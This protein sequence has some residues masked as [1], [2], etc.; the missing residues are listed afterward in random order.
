VAPLLS[1]PRV[2]D[3]IGMPFT[4]MLAA[5]L[6]G[7]GAVSAAVV[8]L[9]LPE[10]ARLGAGLALV[11]GAGVGVGVLAVGLF[12]AQP[13]TPSGSASAQQA[14]LLVASAAGLLAVEVALGVVWRRA[15]STRS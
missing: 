14:A 1:G 9:K 13:P 7:A 4:V 15:G 2:D 11:L 10:D 5:V 12:I 3:A 6:M 8:G